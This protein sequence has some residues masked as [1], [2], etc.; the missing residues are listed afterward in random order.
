LNKEY[1][2]RELMV[3]VS[4]LILAIFAKSWRRG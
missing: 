3:A 2:G 1:I 4:I